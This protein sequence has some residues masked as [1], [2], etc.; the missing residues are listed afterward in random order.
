MLWNAK[1]HQSLLWRIYQKGNRCSKLNKTMV[2]HTVYKHLYK[3][4]NV[5]NSS[6]PSRIH[7][8]WFRKSI[9]WTFLAKC[10]HCLGFT[11]TLIGCRQSTVVVPRLCVRAWVTQYTH[12]WV[13]SSCLAFAHRHALVNLQGYLYAWLI[14]RR[15]FPDTCRKR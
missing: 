14:C 6:N 13:S 3:Y 9:F 1:W 10:P 11:P 5:A 8:G 7:G 12:K 4:F 2:T 15:C